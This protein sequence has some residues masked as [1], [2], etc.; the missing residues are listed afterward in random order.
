MYKK[1]E[2]CQMETIEVSIKTGLRKQKSKTT[3][4]KRAK[5]QESNELG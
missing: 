4:N 2:D 3:E 5:A 1:N